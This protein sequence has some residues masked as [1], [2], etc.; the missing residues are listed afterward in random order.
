MNSSVI[1]L[2]TYSFAKDMLR[3]TRLRLHKLLGKLKLNLS[4][5]LKIAGHTRNRLEDTLEFL[6]QSVGLGAKDGST[7]QNTIVE[8]YLHLCLHSR[9]ES[10]KVNTPVFFPKDM[11]MQ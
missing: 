9:L 2:L 6:F 8:L 1:L 4:V 5:T 3:A 11:Q 7:L 10:P